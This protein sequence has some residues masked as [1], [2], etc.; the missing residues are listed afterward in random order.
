MRKSVDYNNGPLPTTAFNIL[1]SVPKMDGLTIQNP[2]KIQKSSTT[3]A[4]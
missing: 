2:A 1:D 3:R 4:Q